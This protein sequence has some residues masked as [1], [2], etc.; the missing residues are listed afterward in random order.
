MKSL[1]FFLREFFKRILKVS[2]R[3]RHLVLEVDLLLSLFAFVFAG[4]IQ[5]RYSG[6]TAGVSDLWMAGGLY[7]L[8]CG[9][10]FLPFAGSDIHGS[11][12]EH[13]TSWVNN[14]DFTARSVCGVKPQC[15]A[16]LHGRL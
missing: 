5:T 6:L 12:G 11:C 14:C 13:F 2:L 10:F 8:M 16:S 15:Y 4:I 3:H 7:V 9:L 1:Q